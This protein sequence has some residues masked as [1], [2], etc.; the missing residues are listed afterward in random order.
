MTPLSFSERSVPIAAGP[1]RT[2]STGTSPS[3]A[4]WSSRATYNG[5]RLVDVT[6]P[7]RPRG[8]HRLRGVYAQEPDRHR[9]RKSGR[10]RHLREHPQ[11]FVE[12]EHAGRLGASCDGESRTAG[13]R[14]AAH[15]RHLRTSRTRRPDRVGGPRLRLAHADDDP[16][17]ARTTGCSSTSA[18]RARRA[19][20]STSSRSRSQTPQGARLL[21][22]R[23]R[24]KGTP[25]TTSASSS[26]SAMKLGCAGFDSLGIYSLGGADG[27][28]LEEPMMMHHILPGI[29]SSGHSAAFTYDGKVAIFGWEPGG[30][31][32]P[33]L[34]SNGRAAQ[35]ADRRLR[36][37]DG[38][39]EVVL[40]LLR[41]DRR[42]ARA[43]SCCRATQGADEA[44]TIHNYNIVPLRNK[45]REAALRARQRQLHVRHQRRRFHRPGQRE[46]DR[47]RRSEPALPGRRS[48]AATGPTYWYNGRIY[49]SDL[50][51][52]L[53]VWRL[54][55]P[56]GVAVPADCRTR[57]RRPRSSRS[58]DSARNSRGGG[59]RE[60]AARRP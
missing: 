59:R 50:V 15:L 57:T 39:H 36:S 46:G 55:R 58:T 12:L 28:S 32:R 11:P 33:A 13:L 42:A 41:R 56:G 54:G 37:P 9:P 40:L 49:E 25:A 35:P 20:T 31:V 26:A 19:R 5:F 23:S 34:S 10:H 8:D 6:F 43:S 7:S 51:W 30:G 44:C 47:L 53:L 60:A 16:R 27:G 29:P 1:S 4:T 14:G 24:P 3:G 2:S 21:N 45:S 18:A 38:R 52:G 22:S 17:P 48:R